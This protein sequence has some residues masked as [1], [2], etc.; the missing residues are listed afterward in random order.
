MNQSEVEA[1]IGHEITHV[2]NG[3]M[4]TMGLMQGVLNTFVY[5]FATVVGHVVDR[6]VFRN[7]QGQGAAYQITE[8]G[9]E[10]CLAFWLCC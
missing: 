4:I 3:D 10:R 2:A 5:F 1:V 8:D 9:R 6:A 7:E